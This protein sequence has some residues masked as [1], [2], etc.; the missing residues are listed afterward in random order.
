[1]L[2]EPPSSH[3]NGPIFLNVMRHTDLP[4]AAALLAPRRLN[5]YGHIPA[6]FEYT[7]HIY[8]LYGKPEYLFLA[9]NVEYVLTGRYDH[10]MASGL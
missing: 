10:G 7:K 1:M 3:R 5:F 2:M 8:E 4:E 6:A 9:M